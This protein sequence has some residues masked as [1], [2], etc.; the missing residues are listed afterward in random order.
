MKKL[1][2]NQLRKK[3]DSL[4]RDYF[5]GK[6]NFRIY[7]QLLAEYMPK[8]DEILR[9]EDILTDQL[10]NQ[11]AL[12]LKNISYIDKNFETLDKDESDRYLRLLKLEKKLSLKISKLESNK[13]IKYNGK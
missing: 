6:L 7:H 12:V 8:L 3:I 13:G 2:K 5:N 10:K 4:N 11:Y 9:N 1:N